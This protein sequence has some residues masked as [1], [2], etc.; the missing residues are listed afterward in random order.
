[1][2]LRRALIQGAIIASVGIGSLT[3]ASAITFQFGSFSYD[4]AFGS[5]FPTY[6]N[7]TGVLSG[8]NIP[9]KFNYVSGVISGN[10]ATGF[11]SLD[12]KLTFH[13]VRKSDSTGNASGP[14]LGGNLEQAM[15]LTDF[16]LTSNSSFT[17]MGVTGRRNLLS[18]NAGNDLDPS[19]YALLAGKN[20]GSTSSLDGSISGGTSIEFTSDFVNFTGLSDADFKFNFNGIS[21]S[22]RKGAN[23]NFQSFFSQLT[24]QFGANPAPSAI[25]AP[26]PGG[27]ALI[28]GGT[29][30]LS[31]LTVRLRRKK[32]KR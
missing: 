19:D 10:P 30:P 14:T 1:M 23:N 31:I 6:D 20:R 4:T 5:I 27:L 16:S 2:S 15:T 13:A 24:G 28:I 12:A 3:Q 32:K 18:G 11:G 29:I 25:N 26:E 8:I 7:L 22:F 21:P 17:V 9:V